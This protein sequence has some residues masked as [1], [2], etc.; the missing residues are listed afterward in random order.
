MNR[1]LIAPLLLSAG[2]IYAFF[3]YGK[4]TAAKSLKILFQNIKLEKSTGLN[5][6]TLLV[7]FKIINPSSTPLRIESIVGDLFI[8]NKL[9]STISQTL[10][11]TIP[12]NNVTVYSIKMETG[13]VQAVATLLQLIKQKK[14]LTLTFKGQANST[15]FM[16]PI[17]QTVIQL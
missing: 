5:L 9:L 11:V 4:T 1:K 8:N 15:G 7:N 17:Q 6:P 2:V 14:G 16:I 10:P 13:I 12:A 3:L